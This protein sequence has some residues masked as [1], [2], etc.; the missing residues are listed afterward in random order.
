[1][2]HNTKQYITEIKQIITSARNKAH[3]AIN[4][5]M[6]EAYWLI[7]KRIVEE[8]QNGKQRA[9]YGQEII[10]TLS[11]ELRNEFG[12]GF[13]ERILRDSRR[14]YL[15]FKDMEFGIQCVPNLTWS[16]YR[17]I[18]RLSDKNAMQYYITEASENNWSVRT[19]DRN[20]STLYYQRLL[21]S[22]NKEIVIAEMKE[23]TADLQDRLE[24]IKNPA[25]LEFLGLPN[26]SGY[27]EAE[28][29]GYQIL[30]FSVGVKA[31]KK[32]TLYSN[33]ATGQ[34]AVGEC[35]E[36]FVNNF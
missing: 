4:S 20:I 8:E 34:P 35:K 1:M 7:G 26:N 27:I 30:I 22:Q 23:K 25:V 17:L 33:V 31:L 12:T 19:L 36:I 13:G 16:H 24:F 29:Q 9:E 10:K 5:A 32:Q 2:S 28:I 15:C 21:S 11:K 6:I 3:T 14:F 18:L